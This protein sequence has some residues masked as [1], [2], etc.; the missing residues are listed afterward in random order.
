MAH[1]S[2]DLVKAWFVLHRNFTYHRVMHLLFALLTGVTQVMAAPPQPV[3]VLAVRQTPIYAKPTPESP[4]VLYLQSGERMALYEKRGEYRRVR[5]VY[6]SRT[7][8]GYIAQADAEEILAHRGDKI[9]GLGAGLSFVG[10][11][12]K[13]RRDRKS[14]V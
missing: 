10:L 7:H 9:F 2:Q 1:R 6:S 8:Q 14:V 4:V 5:F 12:Q 13:A 11:S 3:D